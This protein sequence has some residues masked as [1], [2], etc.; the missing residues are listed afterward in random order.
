MSLFSW[1]QMHHICVQIN[2]ESDSSND[3]NDESAEFL[4]E[5]VGDSDVF[6]QMWKNPL[7]A[8]AGPD[9]MSPLTSI[10]KAYQHMKDAM[11]EI[12]A[13]KSVLQSAIASTPGIVA[14]ERVD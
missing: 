1:E 11:A 7:P 2:D 3:S 6:M 10:N 9:D 5:D 8:D 13:A 14:V 4:C 12:T